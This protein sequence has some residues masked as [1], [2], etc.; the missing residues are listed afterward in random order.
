MKN[1]L[2]QKLLYNF[3]KLISASLLLISFNVNAA[4]FGASNYE[5][6]V[7]DGKT[8]RSNRE[9]ALL[10]SKCRK[11]FPIL[12]KLYEMKDS[13]IVCVGGGFGY[14]EG[15]EHDIYK[16]SKN[17][18]VT[19]TGKV[20]QLSLRTKETIIVKAEWAENNVTRKLLPTAFMIKT[21]NGLGTLEV[22]NTGELT[23]PKS[24]Y[25]CSEQ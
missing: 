5:E 23:N 22:F 14:S 12:K 16:I 25:N 7:A 8:G 21:L 1:Q 9:L 10:A 19:E 20:I 4:W 2:N 6:C 15:S 18:L 11:Q 13:T 17:Q 24:F 3:Y